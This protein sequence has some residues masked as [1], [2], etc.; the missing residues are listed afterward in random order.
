MLIKICSSLKKIEIPNSV[1][2]IKQNCFHN[3]NN[4]EEIIIN[5]PEGSISGAPWG[6]SV[7]LRAVKWNG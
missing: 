3:V 7:G 4:L 1:T 2:T 5:K 6:C